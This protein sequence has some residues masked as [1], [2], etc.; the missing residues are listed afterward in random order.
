MLREAFHNFTRFPMAI[1]LGLLA[2]AGLEYGTDNPL[3]AVIGGVAVAAGTTL[4]HALT[5]ERP[6]E[7]P[8][9]TSMGQLIIR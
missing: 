6:E 8:T 4:A 7:G 1:L 3:V 2:G 5:D 9:H